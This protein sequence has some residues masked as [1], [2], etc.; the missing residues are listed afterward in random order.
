M[1]CSNLQFSDENTGILHQVADSRWY[2]TA[3]AG[4]SIV[5]FCVFCRIPPTSWRKARTASAVWSR[6]SRCHTT[7]TKRERSADTLTGR[8]ARITSGYACYTS[9]LLMPGSDRVEASA[10]GHNIRT[11]R[12]LSSSSPLRLVPRW[13][14][15]FPAPTCT[16]V[17]LSNICISLKP[18]C[19]QI[20]PRVKCSYAS[21]TDW[22][23]IN[24]GSIVVMDRARL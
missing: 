11:R 9:H 24:M 3:I 8:S 16:L 6:R 12:S 14:S 4:W 18:M 19:F 21:A 10:T 20:W 2:R 22:K 5:R 1:S 13:M 23:R 15:T 7:R 17:N